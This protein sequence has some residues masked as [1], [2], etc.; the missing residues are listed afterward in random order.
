M[1]LSL[2]NAV[3]FVVSF[4]NDE[5]VAP[6]AHTLVTVTFRGKDDKKA[7]PSLCVAVP[8]IAATVSEPKLQALF[9]GAL[10]KDM[11]AILRAWYLEQVA[12]NTAINVVGKH[13]P[14]TLFTVD[15][16]A[17][18]SATTSNGVGRLTKE[19]LTKWFDNS[20]KDGLQADVL[21][22]F[23][24]AQATQLDKIAAAYLAKFVNLSA[25]KPSLDV[26]KLEDM[27]NLVKKTTERGDALRE[28]VLARIEHCMK[29]VAEI[30]EDAGLDYSA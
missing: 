12:G 7:A 18:F 19:L 25:P 24:T 22:K 17:S 2:K 1:T 20:V 8:A 21:M 15:A 11:T 13:V 14:E 23:P 5:I 3:P 30:V 28:A 6:A 29:P 26:A 16:I 9:N 27:A 4:L 10:A